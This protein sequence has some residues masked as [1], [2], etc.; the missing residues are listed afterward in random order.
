V[1]NAWASWCPPCRS[2]FPLFATAATHFERE[3]AFLGLDV[4]D[5]ASRARDFL[6]NHHVPYPSYADSEG[7][8]AHAL[9]GLQGLPTT[10][11][12]NRRGDIA[13]VHT[14]AYSR[15]QALEDDIA[16]HA[17]GR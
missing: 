12:I 16:T 8:A 3:V 6:A 4:S 5:Q 13:Y 7:A 2:E 1:V 17:L 14:G 15:L 10:A 11:F 9:S